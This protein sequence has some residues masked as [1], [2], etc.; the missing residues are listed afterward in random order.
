MW[1]V[2]TAALAKRRIFQTTTAPVFLWQ[3]S[4][5]VRHPRTQPRTL[6]NGEVV[7]TTFFLLTVAHIQL[8]PY[9]KCEICDNYTININ[10]LVV[11]VTRN[12]SF[13][14][15]STAVMEWR[16]MLFPVVVVVVVVG[17]T[18]LR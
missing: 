11:V 3:S 16:K 17:R 15:W 1:A 6:Y 2:S 14:L 9:P 18:C 8:F 12:K 10:V 7:N 4:E 13:P 5:V